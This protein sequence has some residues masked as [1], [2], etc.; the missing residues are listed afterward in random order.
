M[1]AAAASEPVATI[2]AR[3]LA[4]GPDWHVADVVCRAGPHDRPFEEQHQLV[5]IAA[6]IEGSF[7]YRG[8][9]GQ[10]VL[11]PGAFLLGNSGDC[12]VCGHEHAVGDRCVAFQFAPEH[13]AEIAAAVAGSSRFRFPAAMIPAVPELARAAAAAESAAKAGSSDRS[14]LDELALRLAERAI[15]ALADPKKRDRAPSPR[16]QRRISAALR[17]IEAHAEEPLDLDTLAG[18]ACMSKYHFLR[19]FRRITGVTPYNFL[20]GVRLRRAA[21]RLSTTRAP[22]SAIAYEAGFGDLSTFNA[23][24]RA[25]FGTTPSVFR[26]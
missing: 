1:P 10:A 7:Q 4:E 16:D 25:T 22:V 9:A 5:S 20:L 2:D 21:V 3:I 8:P 23:R 17:H 26:A 15:A 11:Y 13:F 19:T 14:A 6:V 24:F 18:V 12:F